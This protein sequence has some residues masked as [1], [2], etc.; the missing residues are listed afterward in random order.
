MPPGTGLQAAQ[1]GEGTHVRKV[2][3]WM[4]LAAGVT[5]GIIIFIM[6]VTGA[7]LAFEKQINACLERSDARVVHPAPNSVRLPMETLLAKVN[8]QKPGSPSAITVHSG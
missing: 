1:S 8:D 6:C 5:A 2:L 4:H 3:F 7:A